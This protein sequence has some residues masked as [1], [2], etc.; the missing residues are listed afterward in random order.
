MN[1]NASAAAAVERQEH[2]ARRRGS[3]EAPPRSSFVPLAILLAAVLAWSAFQASSLYAER[4][5]LRVLQFR[6]EEQVQTSMKVR[7]QLDAI[8]RDMALLAE[9]GNP[10]ARLMVDELRKRGVTINPTA[11][12]TPTK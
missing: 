6:Q 4:D 3:R 2:H 11:A 8:A 12:S 10:S 1:E 9:R 5:T 7:A